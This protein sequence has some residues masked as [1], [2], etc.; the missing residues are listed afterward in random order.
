[1]EQNAREEALRIVSAMQEEHEEQ[2]GPTRGQIGFVGTIRNEGEGA[3]LEVLPLDLVKDAAPV[4]VD[5]N[6]AF[7]LGRAIGFYGYVPNPEEPMP[8]IVELIRSGGGRIPLKPI[9]P[10][11]NLDGSPSPLSPRNGPEDGGGDGARARPKECTGWLT[12]VCGP[13][14]CGCYC[15]HK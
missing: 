9:L 14:G 13:T 12:C 11:R 8:D 4:E 7:A 3:I 2:L 5:A 6:F 15:E 10:V 1:V